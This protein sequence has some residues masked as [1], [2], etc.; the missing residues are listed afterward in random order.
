MNEWLSLQPMPAL[1]QILGTEIL[2]AEDRNQDIR[3][4]FGFQATNPI[5]CPTNPMS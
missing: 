2:R 3:T 4:G 5:R 1:I